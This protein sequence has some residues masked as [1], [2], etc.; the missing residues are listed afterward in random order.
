MKKKSCAVQNASKRIQ[1]FFL[2][3]F[4]PA[5]QMLYNKFKFLALFKMSVTMLKNT[6]FL[7]KNIHN[8]CSRDQGFSKLPNRS[9]GHTI[10]YQYLTTITFLTYTYSI[11]YS[12]QKYLWIPCN[13]VCQRLHFIIY[14]IV[15]LSHCNSSTVKNHF[16]TLFLGPNCGTPFTKSVLRHSRFDETAFFCK[17]PNSF[18]MKFSVSSLTFVTYL[19][20][21]SPQQTFVI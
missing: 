2:F 1:L 6:I 5:V 8:P 9:A 7:H 20:T 18:H 3:P 14:L 4:Y 15:P 17:V 12:Y 19:A 13:I 10:S 21:F 11:Q 16:C